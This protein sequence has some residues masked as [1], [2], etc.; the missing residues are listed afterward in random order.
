MSAVAVP[1]TERHRS[2]RSTRADSRVREFLEKPQR[3]V[4]IRTTHGAYASMGNYLFDP[5][6]LDNALEEAAAGAY[7]SAA[8]CCRACAAARGVRLRLRENEVR[9][10][11][12]SRSALT[13]ATSAL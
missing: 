13:G 8:T 7:D 10:C 3:P 9:A 2:H 5:K 11:S 1:T 4:G 12:N 6:V